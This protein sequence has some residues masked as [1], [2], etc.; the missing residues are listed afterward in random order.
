MA[1]VC[2]GPNFQ[3][4]YLLAQAS[5]DASA[6]V[7]FGIPFKTSPSLTGTRP[8]ALNPATMCWLTSPMDSTAFRKSEGYSD[9]GVTPRFRVFYS[10]KALRQAAFKDLKKPTTT[11]WHMW[12][13]FGGRSMNSMPFSRHSLT[14]FIDMWL[15]R[16]WPITAFLPTF[17]RK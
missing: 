12:V 11:G 15:A 1:A 16:L 4:K 13:E 5:G 17:F 14:T 3:L 2:Y 8:V 7:W 9:F 10:D 6:A